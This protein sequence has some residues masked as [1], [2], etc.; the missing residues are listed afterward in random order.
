MS[1]YLRV[2]L[3]EA[4]VLQRGFDLPTGK[5]ITGEVPVVASTSIVGFHNESAVEGPGVVIGRSGSIGGGQWIDSDFWPLNTTLWV[6]DFKGNDPRFIYF[7]LRSIDFSPFNAGS[8]VPTL[9]RNHLSGIEVALPPLPEQRAIA[10][11]LGALDDKIES[12]RRFVELGVRL[13][14][15]LVSQG[16]SSV[17][18]GDIAAVHKGLSYKGSGL[19]ESPGDGIPMVNLANFSTLG[20]MV[21]S[22]LKYYSG[23][24]KGKHT[25]R[26]WDVVVANTDLTQQRSILGRAALVPPSLNGSIFTHHVNLIRFAESEKN[27]MRLAVWGQ[28]NSPAFRERAEGFATGT[29][30]AGL[31]VDALLD[32]DVKVPCVDDV[33]AA[34]VV[35]MGAWS[36]ESES[37]RL[38][39]IRDALLPALLS[40]RIRVPAAAELV[41]AS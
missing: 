6:K 30:V 39:A 29:T 21:P 24:H 11:I 20:W 23:D 1:E 14:R 3:A 16:E 19:E 22:G 31:P 13:A 28:L 32:F 7:L 18:L 38:E 37:V 5:R 9:N 26:P 35:L 12:N 27:I 33:R 40:G 34:E 17:R 41:E 8:G 25:L 10:E 36:A 4:V 2:S 15:V